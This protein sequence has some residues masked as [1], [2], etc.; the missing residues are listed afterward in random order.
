M[1]TSL[2][3]A[4]R[5]RALIVGSL[6]AGVAGVMLL[7]FGISLW[8][9]GQVALGSTSFVILAVTL[10]TGAILQR[11][12]SRV[13]AEHRGEL[14]QL[15]EGIRAS[16]LALEAELRLRTRAGER[17]EVE[18][19]EIAAARSWVLTVADGRRALV[20]DCGAEGVVLLRGPLV[21][22]RLPEGA[23]VPNRWRIERLRDSG[24]ILSLSG[25]GEPV[26][27]QARA[28][29]REGG[30]ALD[31][32]PECLTTTLEALPPAIQSALGESRTPYR[33]G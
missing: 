10:A 13:G 25:F 6:F 8:F 19:L 18:V 7:D 22:L 20:L 1:T 4:R 12:S 21:D 32:L 24:G 3:T 23:R 5:E 2:V 26:T 11:R 15:Q 16:A 27:S 17:I 28:L 14:A 33:A 31:A 30:A 9:D 29:A